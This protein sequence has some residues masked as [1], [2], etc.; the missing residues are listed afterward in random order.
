MI[1]TKGRDAIGPKT[2][3]P[4]LRRGVSVSGQPRDF[5][6]AGI[7]ELGSVIMIQFEDTFHV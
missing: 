7:H 1:D 2:L 5:F 6:S 4:R 3:T